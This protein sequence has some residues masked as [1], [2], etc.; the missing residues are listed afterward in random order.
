MRIFSLT[1]YTEGALTP[2]LLAPALNAGSLLQDS[3]HTPLTIKIG[4]AQP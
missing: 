4:V 2:G 1:R 3:E